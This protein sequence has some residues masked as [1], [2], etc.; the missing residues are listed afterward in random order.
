MINSLISIFAAMSGQG[1]VAPKPTV[2]RS[3]EPALRGM[4]S[5]ISELRRYHGIILKSNR[6]AGSTA[7][8]PEGIIEIWRDGDKF[9]IEFNDMWGSSN[10]VVSD[11][12]RILD[13]PGTDPI[14][15]RKPGK[16]LVEA[17][18]ALA[19]RGQSASPWFYFIQGPTLLDR[20]DKDREISQDPKS[21]AIVWNSS[22]FGKLTVKRSKSDSGVVSYEIV[23]NN[24]AWQ[25]EM[26]KLNPD[27]FD[28]PDGSASW[29]QVVVLTLARFPRG[30]FDTRVSK[31]RDSQDLTIKLKKPPSWN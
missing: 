4:L 30:V 16:Y 18:P 15:V 20:I 8:Y 31:G 10:L 25:E 17:S 11:G 22:L 21:G 5:A 3:G 24:M 9:R 1:P 23:F 14:V 13:D 29:R 12:K 28:A 6:E 26:F 27:W 2:D 7:Y 19:N